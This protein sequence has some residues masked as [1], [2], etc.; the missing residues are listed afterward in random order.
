M[1]T[2]KKLFIL[3]IVM[4]VLSACGVPSVT[5]SVS[6]VETDAPVVAG[7]IPAGDLVI[8]SGRSEPLIQPVLDA[9]QAKYPD[10]K[11]L[12]KS[13]SNSELANALIEEK[14]NPQADVFIT[15]EIFTAD[16]SYLTQCNR[17]YYHPKKWIDEYC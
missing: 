17:D 2:S 9:F 6:P 15:T 16:L 3:L 7:E 11:I 8:Y 1:Q 10:V 5:E 13:G 14:S 12:L 4:L